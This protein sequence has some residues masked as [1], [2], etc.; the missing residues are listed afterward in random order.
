MACGP[1]GAVHR[2]AVRTECALH[3]ATG[4]QRGQRRA[5]NVW[6]TPRRRR[7]QP[8][9]GDA[10]DG[11]AGLRIRTHVAAQGRYH[12]RHRHQVVAPG[13]QVHPTKSRTHQVAASV[14]SASS[15]QVLD[16]IGVF[17]RSLGWLCGRIH[18]PRIAIRTRCVGGFRRAPVANGVRV[19][20]DTGVLAP[21]WGRASG[22][23]FRSTKDFGL[24][25]VGF[26]FFHFLQLFLLFFYA[27]LFA[28]SFCEGVL[29]TCHIKFLVIPAWA[30]FIV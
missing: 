4:H 5:D 11:V 26:S 15:L 22:A 12:F 18:S 7:L 9:G 3:L 14:P 24:L 30:G 20:A 27:L 6:R 17:D 10:R 16:L 1:G 23:R 21:T 29:G 19:V 28:L 2:L 13:I 25:F 8:P